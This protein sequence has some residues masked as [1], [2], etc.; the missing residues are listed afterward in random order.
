MQFEL[1]YPLRDRNLGVYQN[2][3]VDIILLE[4]TRGALRENIVHPTTEG[5]G[6]FWWLMSHT[7]P[8]C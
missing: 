4:E 5:T 7:I 2:L 8:S 1:V 6:E 3:R